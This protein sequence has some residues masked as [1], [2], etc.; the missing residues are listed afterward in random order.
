MRMATPFFSILP[1]DFYIFIRLIEF[2]HLLRIVFSEKGLLFREKK[3]KK[4]RKARHYG[5]QTQGDHMGVGMHTPHT[6]MHSRTR[7]GNITQHKLQ[8]STEIN[9]TISESTFRCVC[10]TIEDYE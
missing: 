6:R 3:E 5:N 1:G 4:G 10:N 8:E 9:Q 7:A 2:L